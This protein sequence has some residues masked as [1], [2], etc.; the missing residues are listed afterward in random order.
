M[1]IIFSFNFYFTRKKKLKL[2]VH[3]CGCSRTLRMRFSS[4]RFA[5]NDFIRLRHNSRHKFKITQ[6]KTTNNQI[7][8]GLARALTEQGNESV[9]SV[10][11]TVC[12]LLVLIA[13]LVCFLLQVFFFICLNFFPILQ[14]I[15]LV[16]LSLTFFNH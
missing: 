15:S 11:D 14:S 2:F 3:H 7:Q 10:L 4:I 5:C 6:L 1:C 9:E 16:S 12:F 8:I 13:W